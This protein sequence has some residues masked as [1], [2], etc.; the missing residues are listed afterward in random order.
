MKKVVFGM[1]AFALL[2]TPAL[3]YAAEAAEEAAEGGGLMST[4]IIPTMT[5]F[6]PMLIAFAVVA[7]VLMKVVWPRILGVLDERAEKIEGSL[8]KAEEAKIEAE[9]ILVEYEA[10]LADVRKEDAR[11]VEAGRKAGEVARKEIIDQA[12]V[13]AAGIIE[14]AKGSIEASKKAA[15]D[16]LQS[17][18]AELAV[19]IASRLIQAKI[20]PEEDERLI[21]Q[22]IAEMGSFHVN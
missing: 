5:E 12:N 7:F 18:T 22:Y 1:G 19:A 16:E 9:N 15:E 14:H 3:A 2:V 6:I 8:K 10:K 13:E 21:N 4:P 11:I 17:R 20:S